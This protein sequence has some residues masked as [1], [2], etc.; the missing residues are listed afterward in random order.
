[1][2]IYIY[3]RVCVSACVCSIVF[4]ENT[5]THLKHICKQ[6]AYLVHVRITRNGSASS[7][8]AHVPYV[9]IFPIRSLSGSLSVPRLICKSCIKR[10]IVLVLFLMVGI[11]QYSTLLWKLPASSAPGTSQLARTLSNTLG[12]PTA[13][14]CLEKHRKP[15]PK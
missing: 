14:D 7:C 13:K 6:L 4:K 12:T 15:I 5:T 11:T 1:M 3:I 9:Y 8:S 2:Y 10:W